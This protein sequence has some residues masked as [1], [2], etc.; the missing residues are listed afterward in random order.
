[1]SDSK[2]SKN[3]HA[4]MHSSLAKALI[5]AGVKHYDLG[6]DIGNAWNNI[7]G[8]LAGNSKYEASMPDIYTQTPGLQG[9]IAAGEGQQQSTF[10]AQLNLA[11]ALQQQTM[12]QGPAQTLLGQQVGQN[13]AN[14]GA[15]AASVRGANVNPALIARQ[16]AM[17]GAG[18][19]Q[20]GLNASALTQLQ[21]Q[22]NLA[23]LQS[24][25]AQEGLQQQSVAQGALAAQNN[26]VNTATL[27]TEGIN[28]GTANS[29]AANSGALTR[30]IVSG[31]AQ[32]GAAAAGKKAH[33][34]TIK[35]MSEGGLEPLPGIEGYSTQNVITPNMAD[36]GMP[37]V[38][39]SMALLQGGRVPGQAQVAGDS[40][41]NDTEPTMLSPGEAVIPRSI[42]QSPNME[43]KALEFLKHLKAKKKGG[44][45][46]VV[47]SK[48]MAKGGKVGC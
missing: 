42:M 5:E 2:G 48:K 38:P 31:G 10:Q 15:L 41:K 39:F 37:P 30:G 25:M 34:G 6:G 8:S 32:A 12:G 33:G 45:E 19:Q 36:G 22:Q 16:A 1:M 26:A 46:S 27:G 4:V 23:N 3:S 44:Y 9:D 29:N 43:K 18:A 14:Q 21:S 47:N 24:Q 28:A 13:V 20:Q 35:K 7:T 11:Q 17:A 40:E